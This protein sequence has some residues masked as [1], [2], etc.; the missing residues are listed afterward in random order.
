M[1]WRKKGPV[2]DGSGFR[3]GQDRL[4]PNFGFRWK[5]RPPAELPAQVHHPSGFC[6][7]EDPVDTLT[8]AETSESSAHPSGFRFR[9]A[10]SPPQAPAGD[11]PVGFSWGV[12]KT[13]ANFRWKT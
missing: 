12:S 2:A 9:G 7:A 4:Q 13:G 10:P 11:R 3:W 5:A 1:L 8:P 6:F